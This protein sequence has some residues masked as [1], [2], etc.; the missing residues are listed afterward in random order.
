M[1]LNPGRPLI[2]P[3]DL[4]RLPGGS[5]AKGSLKDRQVRDG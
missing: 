3:E 4:G 1:G 2:Q 5:E